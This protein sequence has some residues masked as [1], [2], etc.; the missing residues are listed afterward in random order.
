MLFAADSLFARLRS[1]VRD[2]WHIYVRH[3]FVEQL[4]AGTLPEACFRRYLVQ[5]YLFL[6]H[7]ARAYA[8]AAYKSRDLADIRQAA[9]GLH[10][11]ADTEMRLHV[12]FCEEWGLSEADMAAE[13]E[14]QETMAYTRYVLEAGNAGDVLDLHVALAPCIVGYAEIGSMLASKGRM[15]GNPY[16]AWIEMYAS[17]DYQ[18]AARRQVKHLDSLLAKRGGEGRFASLTETFAEATRLEAAF[19][20]MGLKA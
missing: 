19:W 4:G 7:F 8:L 18:T 15:E 17:D 20:D 5:D 16:R 6:I 13:P 9:A 14:A 1:A 3:P 2:D 10:T 12:S 11:I